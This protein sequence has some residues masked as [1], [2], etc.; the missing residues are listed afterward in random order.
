[1]H[2]GFG[3]E[4]GG[5]RAPYAAGPARDEGVGSRA[6]VSDAGVSDARFVVTTREEYGERGKWGAGAPRAGGET[7]REVGKRGKKSQGES[8]SSAGNS[9][10]GRGTAL[11]RKGGTLVH[12]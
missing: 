5:G 2:D 12:P 11:G 7:E 6:G 8:G 3:G 1:M 9:S 10:P 4:H